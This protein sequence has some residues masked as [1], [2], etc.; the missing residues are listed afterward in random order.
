MRLSIIV[1]GTLVGLLAVSSAFAQTV[2]PPPNE[3]TVDIVNVIG[4]GC[5]TASDYTIS[6]SPDRTAFTIAYANYAV[7]SGIN[8]ATGKPHSLAEN[9]KNCLIVAR[10][11]APAGFTYGIAEA[12]MR[13]YMS[14]RPQANPE[15]K[16]QLWF[17]GLPKTPMLTHYLRDFA[18]DDL[19]NPAPTAFP[20][21]SDTGDFVS[22]QTTDTTNIAALALA[23]GVKDNLVVNTIIST[24]SDAAEQESA[25]GADATDGSITTLFHFSWFTCP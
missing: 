6:I 9:R 20:L 16:L 14:L 3:F 13:G 12:D 17:S 5:G 24:N 23:C 10:V 8:P 7:Y 2:S 18:L 1:S 11:N 15:L 22:W 21:G 25:A 4:S 19:G